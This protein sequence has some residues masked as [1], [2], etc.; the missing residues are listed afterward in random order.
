[1]TIGI[2]TFSTDMSTIDLT[3]VA[4]APPYNSGMETT[5]R[6]IA[7]RAI[8][9]VSQASSAISSLVF[10]VGLTQ[11]AIRNG[12]RVLHNGDVSIHFITD[13]TICL[14]RALP[15]Q[16]MIRLVK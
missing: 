6:P 1:M 9:A 5:I 7:D 13:F 16:G 4:P 11:K 12:H 3:I 15:K 2:F 8:V 14:G 10:W